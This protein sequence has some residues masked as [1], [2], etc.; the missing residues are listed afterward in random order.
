M[1]GFCYKICGRDEGAA[2]GGG[3]SGVRVCLGY[4]VD[5]SWFGLFF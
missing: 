3:G 1:I 2:W 5:G 4:F